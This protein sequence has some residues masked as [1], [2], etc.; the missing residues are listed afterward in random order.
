MLQP[1]KE[2]FTKTN[3]FKT[4]RM[5]LLSSELNA[6]SMSIVTKYPPIL[7][8][9]DILIISDFYL[10]PSPINLVFIYAVCCVKITLER[11]F[12]NLSGRAFE[13]ISVSTFSKEM[14]RQF[15]MHFLSLFL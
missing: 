4:V 9:S 2:S 8:R 6:F 11:T 3:F 10:S 15:L 7:L 5:N 1:K 12:F 14:G 13:I